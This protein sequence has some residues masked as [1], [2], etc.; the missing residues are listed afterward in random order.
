MYCIKLFYMNDTSILNL[1]KL[2]IVKNKVLCNKFIFHKSKYGVS[3][4]FI[5][6]KVFYFKMCLNRWPLNKSLRLF[7]LTISISSASIMK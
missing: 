1:K 6:T 5:Y 4:I 3:C 2:N 7:S